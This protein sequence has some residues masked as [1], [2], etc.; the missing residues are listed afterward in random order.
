MSKGRPRK[1]A[2][3]AERKRAYRSRQKK[4][5]YKRFQA[6]IPEEFMATF[7]KIRES[8]G[9]TV[10]E[11]LCVLIASYEELDTDVEKHPA[12]SQA[13]RRRDEK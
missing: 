2:S 3:D 1:Y 5:G 8:L 12:S 4:D 6:E 9:T 7:T 10:S 13:E 11:T